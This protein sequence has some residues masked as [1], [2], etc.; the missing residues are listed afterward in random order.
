MPKNEP[1]QVERTAV[2]ELAGGAGPEMALKQDEYRGMTIK[3]AAFE[4]IGTCRFVVSLSIARH[5]GSAG[6]RKA[7]FFEPPS[8][9]GLFDDPEEALES[10]LAFARAIIDGEVAGLTVDDL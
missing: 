1:L 4:V 2:G 8:E 7:K 3:A 6:L 9:D 5:D 10:A